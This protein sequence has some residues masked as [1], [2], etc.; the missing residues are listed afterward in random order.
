MLFCFAEEERCKEDCKRV[1][2]STQQTTR[3]KKREKL[4]VIIFER[5]SAQKEKRAP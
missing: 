1:N 5:K 3:E 4:I 2:D